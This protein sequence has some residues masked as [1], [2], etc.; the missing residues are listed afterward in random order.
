[1]I[2]DI[3]GLGGP[4]NTPSKTS[5]QASKKPATASTAAATP[6]PDQGQAGDVQLSQEGRTLQSLADKVNNLPEVNLERVER[7]QAA[8]ENGEYQVDDLVLADKI[9]GAEALLN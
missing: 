4:A 5:E 8:L 6:Q 7:I 3:N 2:R 1:M 9:L